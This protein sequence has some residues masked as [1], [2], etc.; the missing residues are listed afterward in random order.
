MN[1]ELIDILE[2]VQDAVDADGTEADSMEALLLED[3]IEFA[4]R[5]REHLTTRERTLLGAVTV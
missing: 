3:P 2:K 1:D 5:Y 4:Q